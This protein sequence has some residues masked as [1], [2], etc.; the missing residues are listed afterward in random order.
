MRT[1]YKPDRRAFQAAVRPYMEVPGTTLVPLRRW[2]APD[3]KGKSPRDGAWQSKAY[4]NDAVLAECLEKGIN[5]GVRL[6][7]RFVAFDVDPRNLGGVSF[8]AFC[9]EHKLDPDTFAAVLTGGGGVHYIARLPKGTGKLRKKLRGYPGIEIITG[10]GR[11]IV[12]A[13]SKHPS[14]TLYAWD[15]FNGRPAMKDTPE[16]PA[17]VVKVLAKPTVKRME[18]DSPD[19]DAVSPEV[20]AEALSQIDAT[21]FQ[22]HDDWLEFMMA[23]VAVSGG[24]ALEEFVDWSTS[25]PKYADHDEKIRERWDSVEPDGDITGGTFWYICREHKVSKETLDK[26][27]A[28]HRRERPTAAEDFADDLTRKMRA[29]DAT[30]KALREPR[31]LDELFSEA[32]K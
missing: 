17:H 29:H 2:N 14:G 21:E 27:S 6:G 12:C 1:P 9:A 25:D 30:P 20:V 18:A 28:G 7:R 8:V 32:F 15:E 11:Q 31:T 10:D 19:V 5:V 26:I 24:A 13:G 22:D 4:D 23:T 3:D 16:L